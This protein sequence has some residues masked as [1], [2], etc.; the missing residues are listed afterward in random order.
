MQGTPHLPPR[1]A[2]GSPSPQRR[3]TLPASEF[4]CLTPQ[5]A[6]IVFEIER[7]GGKNWGHSP[8][9]TAGSPALSVGIE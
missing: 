4:R 5:D 1:T 6:A 2:M 9:F 8:D 3:H 7:E